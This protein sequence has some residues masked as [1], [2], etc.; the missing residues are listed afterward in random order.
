MRSEFRDLAAYQR[1]TSLADDLHRRIGRWN[2]HDRWSLGLQLMRAADSVGANIAE[3]TGRWHKKDQIR[4][5]YV[6][7]GSLFEAEHWIATAERRGL[8][9]DRTTDRLTGIAQ[10]LTGLIKKR[11]SNLSPAARDPRPATST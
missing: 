1:A 4:L 7:R 6:A 10:A 11:A 9:D 2:S 3:A 8:L 5:L